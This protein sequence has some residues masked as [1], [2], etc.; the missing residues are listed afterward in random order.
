M[1]KADHKKQKDTAASSGRP[2]DRV[3]ELEWGAVYREISPDSPS[4]ISPLSLSHSSLLFPFSRLIKSHVA[5]LTLR[6]GPPGGRLTVARE[7]LTFFCLSLEGRN[8]H[9][10]SSFCQSSRGDSYRAVSTFINEDTF[11]GVLTECVDTY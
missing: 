11:V 8:L 1:N 3:E 2:V 5:T 4:T 7:Y 10:S 6:C 9:F